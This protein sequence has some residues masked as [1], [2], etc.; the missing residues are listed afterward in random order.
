MNLNKESGENKEQVTKNA[1]IAGFNHV[2]SS[3]AE[4]MVCWSNWSLAFCQF[5]HFPN[6]MQIHIFGDLIFYI[7][8]I[9]NVTTEKCFNEDTKHFDWKSGLSKV[10]FSGSIYTS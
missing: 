10:E 7:D 1:E 2:T 5:V 4:I 8:T 6:V 3:T 9:F